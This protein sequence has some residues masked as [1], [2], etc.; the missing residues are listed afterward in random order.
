M[1]VMQYSRQFPA[2]L[3]S[4]T[5]TDKWEYSRDAATGNPLPAKVGTST[6]PGTALDYSRSALI[7]LN[8]NG[9][10]KEATGLQSSPAQKFIYGYKD[11]A[12]A[13]RD[14]IGTTGPSIDWNKNGVVSPDT[15]LV[16]GDL[17][18]AGITGCPASASQ[19]ET[20]KGK[21]D[22]A[23]VKLKFLGDAD[24]LD[25]AG[26]D[27]AVSQVSRTQEITGEILEQ[28]EAASRSF[29]YYRSS[30]YYCPPNSNYYCN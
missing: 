16:S 9:G 23:S 22:W 24:S 12:G 21:S 10:L 29:G 18:S 25:G 6:W 30:R 5:T 3:P 2:L 19:L 15:T 17:N 11:A 13:T 14:A 27:S 28:M 4:G 26:P 20:A 1:S 7:D 8:E